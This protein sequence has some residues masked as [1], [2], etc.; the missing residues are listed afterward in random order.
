MIILRSPEEL[1]KMHRA[2][3]VVWD[4]LTSLRAMV[5]PGVTTLDLERFAERRSREHGARPAFKGYRGF[6]CV[7]CTSVN[8]EVVHGIPSE[9]RRLA[10][11]DIVSIDYGCQL[12]GFYGDAAV[13]IPVG[14]IRPELERL[15]RTTREALDRAIEQ[16]R[17]G[18]RLGDVSHAVQSCA[19]AQ[20]YSV[21]RELVGHAIGTKMHEDLQVPNFGPPGRGPK[22]EP[23]LVLAIEP[24]V[25]AGAPGIRVLEDEWTAVT[26]DGSYSAHFEHTVAVTGNGPWILTRPK[27]VTGP[28][29]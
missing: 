20:G 23:G 12:D 3:L 10:E 22:L 25:S 8:A 5:A 27:D 14:K 19:E 21:V 9:K 13:T 18:N 4:V 6:P 17:P 7:L 2:G 11:G 26:A 29:W 24:M 1:E 16:M 28:A 15:L